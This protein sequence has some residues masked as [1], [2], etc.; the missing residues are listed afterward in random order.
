MVRSSDAAPPP[1]LE[2]LLLS[3]SLSLPHAATPKE[4]AVTVPASARSL[5]PLNC[6]PPLMVPSRRQQPGEPYRA[7]PIRARIVPSDSAVNLSQTALG[8]EG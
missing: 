1:E 2:L 6:F 4:R 7:L 3:L 5:V 8:C